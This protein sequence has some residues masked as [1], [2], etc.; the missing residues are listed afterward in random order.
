M[1]WAGAVHGAGIPLGHW[2]HLAATWFSRAQVHGQV[3]AQVSAPR[4]PSA[5]RVRLSGNTGDV[6]STAR[7]SRRG[8]M[9]AT[10]PLPRSS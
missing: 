5:W 10:S 1:S 7:R 3:H 6:R 4:P 8:V 9:P 2:S